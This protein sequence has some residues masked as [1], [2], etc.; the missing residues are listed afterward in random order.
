MRIL[1]LKDYYYPENCAGINLSQDLVS[2]LSNSG[3]YVDIF[4]PIPCRGITYKIRKEYR[5]KKIEHN[6]NVTIYRYWL[7]YEKTNLIQRACRY[8]LQNI[9]QIWKGLFHDYDVIFLG[10]TPPTMGLVGTIL[11]KIKKKPFVYN[12]QD[13]FPDSM[14]TGNIT[15]KGSIVW[16][17]GRGIEKITYNNA[18]HIIVINENFKKNIL[19]KGVPESKISVINNW[20]D[21]EK[22]YPI[23]RN[24]NNL[25]REFSI[26]T[27]KFI[28]LYAGNFGN[29][30]G[31]SV[32]LEAASLLKKERD[33]HFV[34][35]GGG[36]KFDSAKKI[37]K[38]KELKNVTINPL[39]EIERVPEVYSVGN[40]A[41]ITCKKG[42]GY[43]GMPSKTWSIMACNTPI[44]ASFD[45]GSELDY[46]LTNS[47][48]GV[49]IEPENS[50]SLAKKI[51]EL[52]DNPYFFENKGREYVLKHASKDVCTDKYKKVIQN[53]K[54]GCETN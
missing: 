3:D 25:F 11:K 41:L 35:F 34:I 15:K 30:Q 5:N 40:V 39:L 42:V 53:V 14:I 26:P 17:I 54:K 47:H 8:F 23:A 18:N 13:I 1:M 10:S 6:G 20:I 52:K 51:K 12:V 48:A 31:A 7:P 38:D 22:V 19:A 32:I 45:I 44:I 4:T 24:N 28:V 36:S 16:K 21:T 27:D 37:V 50:F 43:T 9:I 33:I 46:I 2:K 49:C 29:A